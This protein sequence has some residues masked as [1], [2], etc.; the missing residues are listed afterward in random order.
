MARLPLVFAGTDTDRTRPLID[1]SIRPPGLDLTYVVVSAGDLFRRMCQYAEFE[2][3]EMSTS[4]YMALL[5]RGDDRFVGVP[6]FPSRSF[7]HGYIV[8]NADSGIDRPEDLRGK[9]MGFPEYQ[10]TAALWIRAVLQHDHGIG[11]SE[12]EWLEGGFE[13]P[14]YSERL[15]VDL[16][17]EIRCSVIPGQKSL[18]GMLIDGEIDALGAGNLPRALLE[19]RPKVRRLFPNYQQVEADYYQRTGFFPIMHLVVVRRDVYERHRWVPNALLAAFEQAKAQSWQALQENGWLPASLPWL[20]A[21]LDEIARVFGGHPFTY[22]FRP[23]YQ[24][25]RAMTQYS[26]EQ[27]L[28]KRRLEPEELFAPETLE[29]AAN[30]S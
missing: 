25:L 13:R 19:G 21:E 2:A 30:T 8:V 10:M 22:G 26:Y 29:P 6:I 7:R 4:S 15:A 9:R 16:P 20:R 1:G 18:V 12:V 23:N 3:S 5:T 27:G 17:P 14:G 11:P 24:T 28:S